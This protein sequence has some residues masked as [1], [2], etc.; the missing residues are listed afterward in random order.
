MTPEN[1]ATARDWAVIILVIEGIV[2]AAGMLLLSWQTYQ[3]MRRGHPKVRQGL[4]RAQQAMVSVSEGARRV[5]FL[6]A[7]PL[8]R[9]SSVS[10]GIRAGWAAWRRGL[11]PRR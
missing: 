5:S 11:E 10:A 8:V 3:A 2:V 6:V 1:L 4:H 9:V 7:Q